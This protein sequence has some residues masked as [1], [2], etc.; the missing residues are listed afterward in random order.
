LNTYSIELRR[1]WK[2]PGVDYAPGIYRVPDDIS[3]HHA[4]VALIKGVAVKA[5][6]VL[7][8]KILNNTAFDA[9]EDREAIIKAIKAIK[10]IEVKALTAPPE[11]KIIVGEQEPEIFAPISPK[12][13]RPRKSE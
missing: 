9:R 8:T 5:M 3:Q 6:P 13:G 7:E 12:R 4:E 10:A 2:L 11:N 1:E